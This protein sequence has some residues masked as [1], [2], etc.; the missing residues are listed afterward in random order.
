MDFF[1]NYCFIRRFCWVL[2][3]YYDT[4]SF[5][6]NGAKAQGNRENQ[7]AWKPIFRIIFINERC[8]YEKDDFVNGVGFGRCL[9][10]GAG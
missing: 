4:M 2:S 1:K 3:G 10:R 6:N 8:S 5:C 7:E 9:R